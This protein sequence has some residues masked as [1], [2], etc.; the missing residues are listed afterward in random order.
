MNYDELRDWLF[1]LVEQRRLTT[2]R[3]DDL[4]EQRR[5]FDELREILESDPP[6]RVV[7]VVA[8]EVVPDDDVSSL[9]DRCREM[10]GDRPV[11]FEPIRSAEPHPAPELTL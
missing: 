5:R 9:L 1:L 8:G 4:L 6:G 3:A 2:V 7:G 10:F 11:Y